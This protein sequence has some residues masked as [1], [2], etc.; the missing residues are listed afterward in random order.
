MVVLT[1]AYHPPSRR[2]QLLLF[3]YMLDIPSKYRLEGPYFEVQTYL[4]KW[5]GQVHIRGNLEC[6]W[7]YWSED[8]TQ[9]CK[10][11]EVPMLRYGLRV[12]SYKA[13]S[14]NNHGDAVII[15]RTGRCENNKEIK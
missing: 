6:A 8:I 5:A 11:R 13:K 4:M 2:L 3:S 7:R 10:Y 15:S 1:S 9:E 12:A 14:D